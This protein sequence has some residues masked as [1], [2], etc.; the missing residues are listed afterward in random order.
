MENP[1]C[2][3]SDIVGPDPMTGPTFNAAFSLTGVTVPG[4]IVGAGLP[5]LILAGGG[6]LGLVAR[7]Q[8]IA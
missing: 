1:P 6:L 2:F 8:K 5:G 7:R 4:P 3:G